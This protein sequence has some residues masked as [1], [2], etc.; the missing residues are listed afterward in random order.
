MAGGRGKGYVDILSVA[1]PRDYLSRV[2]NASG[3]AWRKKPT[4][5]IR[6]AKYHNMRNVAG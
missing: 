5:R 4:S 6:R 3:T 1:Y 2:F